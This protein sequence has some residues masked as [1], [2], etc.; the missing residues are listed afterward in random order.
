MA[1]GVLQD[2]EVDPGLEEHEEWHQRHPKR[3][4]RHPWGVVEHA[5]DTVSRAL[6]IECC[7]RQMRETVEQ[8]RTHAIRHVLGQPNVRHEFGYPQQPTTRAVTGAGLIFGLRG[9]IPALQ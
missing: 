1:V 2:V 7:H 5:K 6:I 8:A 9:C 3:Q 4:V